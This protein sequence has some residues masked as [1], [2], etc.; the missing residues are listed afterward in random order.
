MAHPLT[1]EA[2][3]LMAEVDRLYT[4]GILTPCQRDLDPFLEAAVSRNWGGSP[5]GDS[6]RSP[7]LTAPDVPA[8]RLLVGGGAAQV[9]PAAGR[10]SGSG[11]ESGSPVES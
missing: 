2:V 8:L 1:T 9:V 6:S 11:L 4:S 7:V 5:A 10:T 3:P